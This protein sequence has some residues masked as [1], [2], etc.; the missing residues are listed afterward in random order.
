MYN[1][2]NQEL[3]GVINSILVSQGIVTTST[4]IT[5]AYVAQDTYLLRDLLRHAKRI[6]GHIEELSDSV[7]IL[8][9]S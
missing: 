7:D 5:E 4:K 9:K 1:Q 8:L 3:I 6:A 2:K